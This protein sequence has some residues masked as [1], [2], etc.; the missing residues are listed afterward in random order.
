[1]ASSSA[2]NSQGLGFSSHSPDPA[3]LGGLPVPV[4]RKN[5]RDVERRL[6]E[7]IDVCSTS[8]ESAPF[9]VVQRQI[10]DAQALLDQVRLSIVHS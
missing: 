8:M 5:A 6:G 1:M 3:A 2:H 10:R 7:A 4:L 9:D